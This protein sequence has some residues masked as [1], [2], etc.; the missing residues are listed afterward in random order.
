MLLKRNG[1]WARLTAGPGP[2]L[3]R[4]LGRAQRL[5]AG[6]RG[7]LAQRLGLELAD[8]LARQSDDAADLLEVARVLAVEP[9]AQLEDQALALAQ[10]GQALAQPLVT[11]V[12]LGQ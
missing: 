2:R 8:A 4:P 5:H 9:E 6:R 10:A 3:S 11:Q 1:A 7:Q 12:R